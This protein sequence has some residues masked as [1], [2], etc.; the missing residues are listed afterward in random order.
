MYKREFNK[1]PQLYVEVVFIENIQFIAVLSYVGRG[2]GSTRPPPT[3]YPLLLLAAAGGVPAPTAALAR[4][5]RRRW[6]LLVLRWFWRPRHVS[7]PFVAGSVPDG[8]YIIVQYIIFYVK[9]VG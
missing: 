6:R 8:T 7:K 1:K 2:R 5:L 9:V 3:P 4:D